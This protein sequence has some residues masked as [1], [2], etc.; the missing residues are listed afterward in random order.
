[1]LDSKER[2]GPALVVAPRSLVFNWKEEAATFA[3][4]LRVLDLTGSGRKDQW[5]EIPN[6]DVVILTYGTLRRDPLS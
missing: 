2:R 4:W 5:N 6:Q 3:P 1:M